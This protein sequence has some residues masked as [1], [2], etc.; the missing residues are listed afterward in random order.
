MT[1]RIAIG[2]ASSDLDSGVVLAF[3][4]SV[5]DDV[6]RIRADRDRIMQVLINLISNAVKF[7]PAGEIRCEARRSG[8]D[9]VEFAVVDTGT[10]I[11]PEEQDRV[12]E[13]FRQVGDTLTDKPRGTGLGLAICREIVEQ[14]GGQICVESVLGAGSRFVFTLPRAEVREGD[15]TEKERA[16]QARS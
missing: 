14:H 9:F 3:D 2:G 4:L 10:G 1:G 8:E 12:F 11:A 6:P 16:C 15:N 5:A 7:T 13:K